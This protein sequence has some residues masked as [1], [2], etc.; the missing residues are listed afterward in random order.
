[1]KVIRSM[2]DPHEDNDVKLGPVRHFGW[3]SFSTP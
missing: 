1:M 3:Q 2:C